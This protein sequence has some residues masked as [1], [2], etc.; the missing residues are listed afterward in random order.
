MSRIVVVS[1]RI[2]GDAPP[3]G[4]LVFAL[5]DMLARSGGLWVGAADTYSAA[6]DTRLAP[7]ACAH[8]YGKATFEISV[9]EHEAYYL[10]YANAV[11]WPL[12]HRR[13]D[14][15]D[16]QAGFYP[17]Y[18]A[19]NARV[20][21]A[22][23]AELR[24]DDRIWVH[25]YHFLPLAQAL[26]AEGVQNT[27]GFFL[28]IPFPSA[29]DLP[30]LPQAEMVPGWLAAYD[31]VGLQSKRDVASALEVFRAN[32]GCELGLDGRVQHGRRA[33]DLRA[34]PIG[35]DA[36]PFLKAAR[37]AEAGLLPSLVP[38]P[39][40][41]PLIVGVDR[42]DYSKGIPQRIDAFSQYLSDLHQGSQPPAFVQVAPLSRADVGAYQD[43]RAELEAKA[44]Q[45]NA[46]FGTLGQT[47]LRY[48][49]SHVD[50]DSLAQLYAQAHVAMV[51]PLAD[52]MNL[53]AKEFIAAQPKT[54]PGVLILSQFAG[55]AEQMEAALIVNP[56]DPPAMAQSLRTALS[57]PLAER[58]ARHAALLEGV[59]AQDVHHWSRSFLAT[60]DRQTPE[61]RLSA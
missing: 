27:I 42:L 48:I 11:L 25:D 54:D 6:P 35:I 17:A 53:V 34:L 38:R 44:G 23:A 52:G 5:H 39:A 45:I 41:A 33:L 1:N 46:R 12:C 10:G 29:A 56:Y 7:Q 58:Q 14:L 43:L 3:S 20:A 30:A 59:L 55:A 31:L 19:V 18:A 2:P 24:P 13:T 32:D 57:M 40:E 51:T 49:N 16:I 4:G 36:E 8:G 9:E 47:P 60:L 28:H 26:R 61:T 50:R 22:L 21:K 37:E 15:L